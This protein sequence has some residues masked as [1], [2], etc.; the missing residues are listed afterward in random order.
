MTTTHHLISISWTNAEAR[1][2]ICCWNYTTV[3]W[4]RYFPD[5]TSLHPSPRCLCSSHTG[6]FAGPRTLAVGSC[7]GTFVLFSLLHV[8]SLS[9]PCGFSPPRLQVFVQMTCPLGRP[10]MTPHLRFSPSTPNPLYL[11]FTVFRRNTHHLKYAIYSIYSLIRGL[12]FLFGS[13]LYFWCLKWSQEHSRCSIN[14]F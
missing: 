1:G 8:P 4:P 6:F 3:W 9:Q 7:L 14:I 11:A 5:L 10:T 13:L 2:I 12:I